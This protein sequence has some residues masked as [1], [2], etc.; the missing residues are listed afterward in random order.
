LSCVIP[1][2]VHAKI[3]LT[4]P[5]VQALVVLAEDGGE[6]FG[7]FAANI[8]DAKVIRTK[9]ERYGPIVLSPEAWCDGTL[10]VAVLIRHCSRNSCVSI[11]PVGG[12]T[13]LF[14]F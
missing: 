4:I 11:P 3:P 2:N 8:R 9:C 1:V 14:E 7:M 6:V 5:I 10:A 12:R 13:F